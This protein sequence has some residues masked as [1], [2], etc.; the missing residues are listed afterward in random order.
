MNELV[1]W[2]LTGIE[3]AGCGADCMYVHHC[4]KGWG[5]E[6]EITMCSCVEFKMPEDFLIAMNK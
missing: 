2:P 3:S 5:Q 4:R 6:E 1:T